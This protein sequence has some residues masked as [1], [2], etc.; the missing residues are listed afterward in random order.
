MNRQLGQQQLNWLPMQAPDRSRAQRIRPIV[1]SPPQHPS[2]RNEFSPASF[3]ASRRH[4]GLD[5]PANQSHLMQNGAHLYDFNNGY[6][7]EIDDFVIANRSCTEEDNCAVFITNIPV[8]AYNS[9]VLDKIHE[10]GIFSF[11]RRP[12]QNG[13]RK[14]AVALAFKRPEAAKAFVERA[15]GPV[16]YVVQGVR[17]TVV[18]SRDRIAPVPNDKL[19]QTRLL[20]I[21]GPKYVIFGDQIERFLHSKIKFVLVRRAEWVDRAECR[22]IEFEFSSIRGQ[23]RAAMKALIWY[24]ER[25]PYWPQISINYGTDPCGL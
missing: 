5:V 15:N 11:Y 6:Q 7:G 10:G 25:T 3:I 13:H 16:G 22:T 21:R 17:L 12:P 24:F 2:F 9:E 14:C 23:S 20:H 1:R 8:Q 19:R 18:P 4:R